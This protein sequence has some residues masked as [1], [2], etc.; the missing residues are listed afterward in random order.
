MLTSGMLLVL[1][2]CSYN[3][4]YSNLDYLIPAYINNF[5]ELDDTQE[6]IVDSKT[7]YLL[8]WHQTEQLP[9]YIAWLN[10][11]KSLFE[12]GGSSNISSDVI[13]QQINH[14]ALFWKELKEKIS[15][16]LAI[17]LPQLNEDQLHELFENL[18]E[19]NQKFI[20]EN[21]SLTEKEKNQLYEERLISGFEKWLGYLT[22]EQITLLSESAPGFRSLSRLRLAARF[23]WQQKT[24]EILELDDSTNK[25]DKL[26]KL[27]LK[28]SDKN[29]RHYQKTN[30]SN[31]KQLTSL[32][33][34]INKSIQGKQKQHLLENLD[35]YIEMLSEFE[36]H[37]WK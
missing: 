10:G 35:Y 12:K 30:A 19:D 8:K 14:S 36:K 27:F 34:H 7:L 16:D 28:L 13:A 9:L 37:K 4:F 33:F 21:I 5:V 22:D 15:N 11:I 17:V 29:E 2:S 31:H 3:M 32:I 6:N 23:E 1:S 24:R 26:K 20:R 25:T 18:A